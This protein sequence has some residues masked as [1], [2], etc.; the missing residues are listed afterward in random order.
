MLFR[1][2][3]RRLQAVAIGSDPDTDIALIKVEPVWVALFAL[4]FLG[5]DQQAL[6]EGHVE[7]FPRLG[8]VPGERQRAALRAI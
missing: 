5:E 2:D 8:G 6:L 1:S 7:A 4:A 3:G